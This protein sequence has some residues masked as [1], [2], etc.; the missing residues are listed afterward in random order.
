MGLLVTVQALLYH[1]VGPALL[2]VVRETENDGVVG[3][4]LLVQLVQHGCDMPVHYRV[5]VRVEA[6]VFDAVLC[7]G[8][9]VCLVGKLLEFL[10]GG[11][12]FF[13]VII[14]VGWKIDFLEL[15]IVRFVIAPFF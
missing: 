13:Q 15:R 7:A 5:E 6:A 12:F 14:V 10:L 3:E 1:L 8:A 11:R 9:R 2:P 4:P